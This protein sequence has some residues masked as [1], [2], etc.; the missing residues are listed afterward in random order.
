MLPF[1]NT[2]E[3]ACFFDSVFVFRLFEVACSFIVARSPARL[4]S[5]TILLCSLAHA[6]IQL[7]EQCLIYIGLGSPGL[8]TPL[9]PRSTDGYSLLHQD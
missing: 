9:K 1:K 6:C 8:Q 5:Q 2:L 7:N 4:R 3:V